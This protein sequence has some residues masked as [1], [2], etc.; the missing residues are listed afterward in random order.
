MNSEDFVRH[1]RA[2]TAHLAAYKEDINRLNV[3]PVPDGDT[4]TNMS[5]TL[6][7]VV[8]ELDSLP[9]NASLD[10]FRKAVT[11][12]SLMG[13]RGNSGVITSQILRGFCDGLE[14][15]QNFDTA[16]L[17][18]ALKKS[19][20]VAFAAVRKP[21]EG[22]IL[23][24][25]KDVSIE[26]AR[27]DQAGLDITS[28]LIALVDEAFDS[29]Q[30]TPQ[31]LAVLKENG[32]VDAGGYGLALLCQGFVASWCETNLPPSGELVLT[33]NN[34]EKDLA[35]AAPSPNAT[36]GREAVR[37]QIEQ[38]NDWDDSEYLYCTEF[39]FESETIDVEAAALWLAQ[40]GDSELLVGGHPDFK[41]H[42][43]TDQPGE[44]L[45]YFAAQG[46]IYDVH[47]NNMRM[48]T[49]ERNANL[50]ANATD[51]IGSAATD[52]AAHTASF[53]ATSMP[54][55]PR[56]F[57]TTVEPSPKPVSE[58]AGAK[59][60]GYVA[61]ASGSGIHR[62]LESLGVD[63]IVSGGQ[64]MNPST[65]ELL[66]AVDATGAN[67]VIIFPNNKNIIMAA[68]VAAEV[69]N[70]PVAVVPTRSV[71]ESF[72]ALFA[73][74]ASLDID[75]EARQ[76]HNA[77]SLVRTAEVTHAIK[78]A[79][80]ENGSEIKSGDIIGIANDH[81]EVVGSDLTQ[82]VLQLVDLIANEECDT[83]TLLAGEELGQ[84]DFA[85]LTTT[86]GESFPDLEI[87]A[88]RGEQ[89]LYPLVMAAE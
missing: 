12:G 66:A 71:P 83:L 58:L 25:V 51:S 87:D 57:S 32:V 4:G 81:I 26:A 6:G 49:A 22:T 54:A 89:P 74:D 34:A 59:Q 21:V 86:I 63:V 84:E 67:E 33:I 56:G 7:S 79:V 61:V 16:T 64:T 42:V 62:I 15:A 23:T 60:R 76:M 88:Q 35:P 20:E 46:Q 75:D 5:L 14:G 41:V 8:K 39:L 36:G 45:N 78:D 47:V 44:V 40:I 80:S 30:R 43:H 73:A 10:D 38:L 65:A 2:A 37:V 3:F 19:V 69:S 55:G 24:V 28:A 82:V 53:A 50:A 48:Q 72:S 77:A 1:F 68:Q 9:A 13:A 17:A 85:A 29:V 27:L 52:Q 70:I 18:T 31:L 11:H